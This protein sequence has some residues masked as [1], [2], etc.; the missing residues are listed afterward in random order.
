MSQYPE[1]MTLPNWW[2][3]GSSTPSVGTLCKQRHQDKGGTERAEEPFSKVQSKEVNMKTSGS[4]PTRP[5]SPEQE[6]DSMRNRLPSVLIPAACVWQYVSSLQSPVLQA[7]FYQE[8]SVQSS[9]KRTWA[10]NPTAEC[11]NSSSSC[12]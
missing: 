3:A 11:M 5:S 12:K 10:V 6:S 9:L 8:V 1:G 4:N 7:S 2:I